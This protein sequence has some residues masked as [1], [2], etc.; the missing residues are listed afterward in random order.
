MPP[1]LYAY[2]IINGIRVSRDMAHCTLTVHIPG[3]GLEVKSY[4]GYWHAHMLA[5]MTPC[6]LYTTHKKWCLYT[7]VY[8]AF[9]EQI[10]SK[11]RNLRYIDKYKK[12][13]QMGLLYGSV[14]STSNFV[15]HCLLYVTRAN[16]RNISRQNLLHS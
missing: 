3:T 5:W 8:S 6:F 12:E 10:Q 13:N 4:T 15:Y 2:M 1:T 7:G 11:L 9:V 14:V 16:N